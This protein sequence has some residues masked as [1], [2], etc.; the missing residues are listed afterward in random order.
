MI[1]IYIP[2]NKFV[3]L[4]RDVLIVTIMNLIVSVVAGCIIFAIL[5]NL[6]LET[7]TTDIKH[8]V[9]GGT[10]LAFIS[11]PDAIAKF[12]FAPQVSSSSLLSQIVTHCTAD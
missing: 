1:A 9:K 11:Y 3:L 12:D 7:G 4:Y 8:V 2:V 10:G 6:A 5:G